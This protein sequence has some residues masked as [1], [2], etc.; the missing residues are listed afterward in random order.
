M[1]S[2]PATTKPL[3]TPR[4]RLGTFLPWSYFVLIGVPML[5][6]TMI[7]FMTISG[8]LDETA[9]STMAGSSRLAVK[10]V[11]NFL[12]DAA[13]AVRLNAIF[14]QEEKAA[15]PFLAAFRAFTQEQMASHPDFSLIYFGDEAGNHWLNKREEDGTQRI[16]VIHR[17]LDTPESK[18][19]IRQAEEISRE[20]TTL[21]AQALATHGTVSQE[22]LTR[23]ARIAPLLAPI[24]QTTWYE[25]D[26][27]HTL[28]ATTD[29]YKVYDPRLRP[30]YI[31]ARRQ[32]TGRFWTDVYTWDNSYRGKTIHQ[33]GITV[34]NPVYRDQTLIGVAGIDIVLQSLSELLQTNRITPNSRMFIL[35]N[36]GGVVGLPDY[37][38]VLR[39]KPGA[40]N[41][42]QER[43]QNRITDVP[44][45]VLGDSFRTV[46]RLL[47]RPEGAPL[48]LTQE[49]LFD[50]T[51]TDHEKYYGFY[52]PLLKGHEVPWTI[53]LVVPEADFKGV[54]HRLLWKSLSLLVVS[55]VVVLVISLLI[56]RMILAPVQEMTD[57]VEDMADTLNLIPSPTF[58]PRFQELHLA[59]QALRSLK[60]RWREILAQ[61]QS[62]VQNIGSTSIKLMVGNQDLANRTKVQTG[63]LMEMS[64]AMEELTVTVDQTAQNTQRARTISQEA[65]T[66]FQAGKVTLLQS[67]EQMIAANQHLSQQLQTTNR[68]TVEAMTEIDESAEKMAGI[69]TFIDDVAFQTNLLALNAAV[70]AAKAGEQGRGFAVVATEVRVLARRSSR[71]SQEMKRLLTASGKAVHRGMTVV[72]QSEAE[73]RDLLGNVTGILTQFRQE[74]EKNLDQI[75]HVV[76]TVSSMIEQI[77]HA[78]QQQSI[79]LSQ[80]NTAIISIDKG[81]RQN[82]VLAKDVSGFSTDMMTEADHLMEQTKIFKVE[83]AAT[84]H[85]TSPGKPT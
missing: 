37:Q 2:T 21:E 83:S 16:R 53:G 67:M 22:V 24:L 78:S 81:A 38:Q 9:R 30:W 10:S 60:A 29:A 82:L 77:S 31:G 46:L 39:V 8:I 70:E 28:R 13:D 80:I 85:Y 55:L 75:Q 44:D 4:L 1:R 69:I 65:H 49:L 25:P 42:L 35:D 36:R 73:V 66:L 17:L 56:S 71:A 26:A 63:S 19:A 50:F 57:E 41:T 15:E 32:Q 20:V 34:S 68:H 79:G 61:T 12:D 6:L 3:E 62:T 72:Q 14:F 59:T 33:V 45:T 76:L 40:D 23:Q 43:E 64:S 11:E 47:N 74:S 51:S 27:R 48:A 18:E 84:G 58:H 52:T 7:A 5:A 54:A